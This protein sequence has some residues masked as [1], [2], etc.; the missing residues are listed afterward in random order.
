MK[1]LIVNAGSSSLKYQLINMDNEAT[2]AQ[3][4]IER[5]GIEGD[6]AEFRAWLEVN[7]ES[8]TD[9]ILCTVFNHNRRFV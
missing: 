5:I 4:M 8:A 2:I 7:H 3:G 6:A 9:F 1:I